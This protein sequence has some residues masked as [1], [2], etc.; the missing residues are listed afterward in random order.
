[1][2]MGAVSLVERTRASVAGEEVM[3]E[4]ML[5]RVSILSLW[6]GWGRRR[7]SKGS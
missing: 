5:I 6:E 3:V 7:V 1:M 4:G 2:R